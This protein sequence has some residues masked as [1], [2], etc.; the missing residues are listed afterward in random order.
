MRALISG[1]CVTRVAPLRNWRDV[2]DPVFSGPRHTCHTSH[3]IFMTRTEK[4]RT[5]P[6]PAQ[7][8][9]GK[10]GARLLPELGGFAATGVTRVTRPA[11]P[12]FP[13]SP[14]PDEGVTACVR[15]DAP[16]NLPGQ[17]TTRV[18]FLAGVSG[19]IAMGRA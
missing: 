12:A 19:D 16:R 5:V 18:V 7:G 1:G 15:S 11:N 4:V 14:R 9:G 8:G 17:I 6:L 3:T 13:L 10:W 2:G